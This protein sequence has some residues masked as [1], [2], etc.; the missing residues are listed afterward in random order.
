M[1]TSTIGGL[2]VVLVGRVLL[3]SAVGVST[4]SMS[5]DDGMGDGVGAVTD[6]G[7]GLDSLRS[8][9]KD[10]VILGNLVHIYEGQNLFP[11]KSL[12]LKSAPVHAGR[13]TVLVKITIYMRCV[14]VSTSA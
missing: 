4:G 9:G 2:S 8:R 14:C 6:D 11:W 5:I 3:A 1:F 10:Q 7:V 13:W 12:W